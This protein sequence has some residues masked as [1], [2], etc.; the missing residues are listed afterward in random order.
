[1]RRRLAGIAAAALLAAGVVACSIHVRTQDATSK[2]ATKAKDAKEAEEGKDAKDARDA[3][4]AAPETGPPRSVCVLIFDGL[5]APSLQRFL[6]AGNLPYLKAAVVDRA[7]RVETAVASLPTETYPNVSAMVTGLFPG[8]HGIPANVWLDR[9]IRQREQHTNIFRAYSSSDFLAP[10]I[11]TLFER[12]PGTS[13]CIST[14]IFRGATVVQKNVTAI[15]AS[16]L[17]NDWDFLNRKTL[18]DVGDAYA[19]AWDEKK[20][21][22]LVWSHYLGPDE[23]EHF[24]GVDSEVLRENLE[25]FDRALGRLLRR[26]KKRGIAERILFVVVSDHGH[27]P[28]SRTV[29]AEELV[30]RALFA[31]PTETDCVE[32]RCVLAA[33]PG[34][35][36]KEYD[37]GEAEIAVGAYRGAMIW[38]PSTRPPEDVPR[39][40]KTRKKPRGR[41]PA[42]PLPPTEPSAF[43]ATLARAP[44]VRLVAT[45]G[46]GP[47]RVLVYGPAGRGEIVRVQEA[48]EPDLYSYRVISGEDPL[49][50]ASY[51]A[52][53]PLL[54]TLRTADEWLL[55]TARTQF[56]DV[57]VQL[58]EF[59]DSPRSPDVYVSPA[60]GWGFT[61]GRVGGHGS[62]SRGDIVVPLMFAGPGVAPGRIR[63]ARTVDLT[64]TLLGYLGIPFDPADFDGDDL[65]IARRG[66][67]GPGPVML[68][69]L[70][71]PDPP[72]GSGAR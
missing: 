55:A 48:N 26:L 70:P 6:D 17:R 39:A 69:P 66:G 35:K 65:G 57:A 32:A 13:V 72:T 49:G 19:G 25:A 31:H 56:P 14:P 67:A 68:P 29:D 52:V 61:P 1:V 21:P 71:S 60:D 45:R 15:V 40:F 22:T 36:K 54:G 51:D 11:R 27:T 4:G 3:K 64:P 30:H 47:G 34:G 18:D 62:I 41:G 58:P 7:L 5:P 42:P 20:I 63:V 23:V 9:R 2:E 37:V 59:F 12:I 28:Y 46:P 43:A 8:H 33:V 10:G 44:E 16:Y 50:Y 38:L 53:R 24:D